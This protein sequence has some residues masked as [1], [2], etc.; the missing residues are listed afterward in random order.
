MID[1]TNFQ[2]MKILKRVSAIVILVI[3]ILLFGGCRKYELP[4]I[5]KSPGSEKLNF[6][7]FNTVSITDMEIQNLVANIRKQDSVFKFLPDFVRLIGLPKWDKVL[8]T[9]NTNRAVTLKTHRKSR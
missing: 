8:Y 4:S 5:G 9:L 2:S 7:F 1:K 3:A 6:Q